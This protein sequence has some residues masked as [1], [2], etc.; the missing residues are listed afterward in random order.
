MKVQN[1]VLEY[2]TERSLIKKGD[3]VLLALSGGPDSVCLLHLLRV[4][5][6]RLKFSL[7]A[8]HFDHGIRLCSENDSDFC[9]VL[10]AKYR[11][12]FLAEKG[13]LKPAAA[14]DASRKARYAFLEKTADHFSC[15]SVATGHQL[16]DQAE[17]IILHLVRGTGLQGLSGIAPCRPILSGS[18]INL[19]RPMLSV[20]RVEVSRFLAENKHPFVNDATNLNPKFQRNRIRLELLP[21]LAEY[22]TN[23]KGALFRMAEILN[24]DYQCISEQAAN[25]L[26][27]RCYLKNVGAPFMAPAVQASLSRRAGSMNRALT[28]VA[29]GCKIPLK[30]FSALALSVQ[31]EVLRQALSRLMDTPY[32]VDYEEVEYLR[33]FFLSGQNRKIHISNNLRAARSKDFFVISFGGLK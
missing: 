26:K 3:R 23:I 5:Q 13:S 19:I 17:T 9:R 32:R 16:D 6:T 12:P 10:S 4:L 20:S 30:E 18:K 21:L 28:N 8:G 2:V 14:E 33:R 7:F 1:K 22:N 24:A 11:I 25:F 29:E 27:S 15:H 31:R